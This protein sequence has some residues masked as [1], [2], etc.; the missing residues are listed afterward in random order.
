MKELH[1]WEREHETLLQDKS[2]REGKGKLY[3]VKHLESLRQQAKRDE[4]EKLRKI[5][6]SSVELERKRKQDAKAD[7]EM[8]SKIMERLMREQRRKK[9]EAQARKEQEKK[10]QTIKSKSSDTKNRSLNEKFYLF[11]YFHRL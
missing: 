8:E 2:Q 9:I 6:E 5:G 11:M 10:A 1:W 4:Q 7:K 3:T